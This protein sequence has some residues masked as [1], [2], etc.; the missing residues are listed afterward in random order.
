MSTEEDISGLSPGLYSLAV[1]DAN[2]CVQSFDPIEIRD[3]FVGTSTL[4]NVDV[5][6]FPN[7][8]KEHVYIEIDD[9]LGFDI[10]L[11]GLDGRVIKAWKEEKT[12]DISAVPAGAYLIEGLSG[13]KIFRQRLIIAR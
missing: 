2:G 10:R 6:L 9:I 8:A 13:N 5:R 11:I 7:P 4:V 3:E 12:L 1:I